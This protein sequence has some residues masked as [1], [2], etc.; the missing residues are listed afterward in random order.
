MKFR[1]FNKSLLA[2]GLATL[3][4]V[5]T[6]AAVAT[7]VSAN[8]W[9]YT[10]ITDLENRGI[11]T[12]NSKGQFFPNNQ[13][14]YF[15]VADILAKATGYVNVEIATNVDETFK[16]QIINNYNNQKSTLASYATK[17]STWDKLYDQQVAYI[18]GRGFISKTDLDKFITKANNKETKAIMTKQ[19][20]AVYIVRILGK[21]KQ[22]KLIMSLVLLMMKA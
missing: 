16:N 13:M 7:D 2:L 17:Y 11:V 8:H 5:S 19:D 22:L 6:F 18:L 20:L 12:Y 15:E 10:A 3:Y 9:A 1:K 21:E 14:T 4:T